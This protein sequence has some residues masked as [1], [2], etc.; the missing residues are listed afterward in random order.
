[1]ISFL[2]FLSEAKVKGT[3]ADE[4]GSYPVQTLIDLVNTHKI[5]VRTRRIATIAQKN[6]ETETK[7]GNLGKMLDKPN[8]KF[9]TRS[10]KADTG[11]PILVTSD[12]WIA[13]GAHR[14]AKMHR[15]G[16][17]HIQTHTITKK[18]LRLARKKS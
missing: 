10:E 8:K 1:M 11:F 14:L 18:I 2:Q 16:K 13:D 12:G 6:R 5:P 4:H 3:Y 9:L 7:E 17:T 15:A